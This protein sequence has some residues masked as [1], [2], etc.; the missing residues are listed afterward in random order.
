MNLPTTE[1]SLNAAKYLELNIQEAGRETCVPDKAF[2][3]TPK[4]YHLFHYVISGKG[5]LTY[6]EKEYILKAGDFFYIAPGDKPYYRPDPTDPWT[7]EW[8]GIGGVSAS[9]LIALAGISGDN[10]VYSDKRRYAKPFFDRMVLSQKAPGEFSLDGLS[11]AFGL[12]DLISEPKL[13]NEGYSQK[14][15]HIES[16]KEFIRNNYAF[17]ISVIDIASSVGVSPNYLSNIFKEIEDSSP[18]KYLIDV[19]MTRAAVLLGSSNIPVKEVGRLCGYP[20][21]LHFS[22]AFRKRY[23]MSPSEYRKNNRKNRSK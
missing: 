15:L 13:R 7:Y 4:T 8:V 5:I 1:F 16:A 18:K 21:Q 22:T 20:K 10:P 2:T 9:N 11:A 6:G 17:D 19:R 12:F 14:K 3:F 23:E